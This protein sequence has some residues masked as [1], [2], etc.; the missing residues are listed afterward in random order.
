M[1]KKMNV[2]VICCD[3]LRADVVDHT[4]KDPVAM[5]NVDRLRAEGTTFTRAY[6]DAYP[7][8]PSRRGFYTGRRAFP[9]Q[10]DIDDRGSVPNLV[11]WYAIPGE[12]TTLAETLSANGVLTGLVSDLYHEF[13]P[14]MNFTRGFTSYDYIRGQETDRVRSGPLDKVDLKRYMHPDETD[15]KRHSGYTQYLLNMMDRAG[16]EEYL[17]AR[18]FRSA[19]Q[20]VDDNA[21]QKPFYLHIESFAPHEFWDPPASFADAYFKKDGVVD[22]LYPQFFQKRFKFTEDEIARTKAL[23]YGYC[24]FVDRWIGRFMQKLDEHKLW[25]DTVVVFTSDH[26][27]ELLDVDQF[28]KSAVRQQDFNTR[29]NMIVRHPDR[30]FAGQTKDAFAMNIDLAPTVCNLLGVES[31]EPYDGQDLMPIVEGR[32]KSK[33][34]H[35][36]AGWSDEVFIRTETHKLSMHSL[37]PGKRVELYDLAKD[38]RET[39]NVAAAQPAVVKDLRGKIEA[40]LGQPLPYKHKHQSRGNRAPGLAQ[41]VQHWSSSNLSS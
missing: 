29:I 31:T 32:A 38:P 36:I 16:E 23:Y 13:K 33:Y 17:P 21:K 19:M 25:D 22:Y 24:T 10:H 20:W 18:V 39:E 11:G 30:A 28:G 37:E 9:F 40:F 15:F 7:T 6:G 5:P 26:G 14:T 41:F 35:V 27:T 4:W 3:T 8:I 2:V 1:P 12:Y 34:P